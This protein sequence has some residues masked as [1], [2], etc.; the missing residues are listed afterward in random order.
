M[1][2]R[3]HKNNFKKEEEGKQINYED[4]MKKKENIYRKGYS[5]GED[6]Q[7]AMIFQRSDNIYTLQK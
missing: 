6:V 1:F 7:V 4:I 5:C 3:K 2:T